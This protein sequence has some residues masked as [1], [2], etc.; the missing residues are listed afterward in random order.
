MSANEL[1]RINFYD[2]DGKHLNQ[3]NTNVSYIKNV[4]VYSDEFSVIVEVINNDSNSITFAIDE[5]KIEEVIAPK[6]TFTS[7]KIILSKSPVSNDVEI[8]TDSK[9]THFTGSMRAIK[10]TI[11]PTHMIGESSRCICG[12]CE[13]EPNVTTFDLISRV[14]TFY[15]KSSIQ[16]EWGEWN[17]N[18]NSSSQS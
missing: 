17:F 16:K 1:Y 15:F 6:S 2:K 4:R 11:Q 8:R 12:S 9:L 5:L 14:F 18:A 7:S 3:F 13:C 10:F